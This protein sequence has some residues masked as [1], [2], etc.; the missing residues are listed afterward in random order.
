[1]S[2]AK[3]RL[4]RGEKLGNT[5]REPGWLIGLTIFLI[6]S[7]YVLTVFVPDQLPIIFIFSAAALVLYHIVFWLLRKTINDKALKIVDY[8]YLGLALFGVAGIVDVQSRIANE[9]YQ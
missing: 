1:M 8:L 5:L 9:R 7:G 6:C 3:Q 4:T 2:D